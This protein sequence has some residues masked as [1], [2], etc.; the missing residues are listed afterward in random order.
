MII[1]LWRLTQPKANSIKGGK[2]M[3]PA[4]MSTDQI[5][6]KIRNHYGEVNKRN[7]AVLDENYTPDIV[8]HALQFGIE[9][10][11]LE[12]M[13]PAFDGLFTAFPDFHLAVED[14]IV[15]G[16]KAAFRITM[17]GTQKGKFMN[18][19]PTGQK[20]T[21]TSFVFLRLEGNKIAEQWEK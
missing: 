15:E 1:G 19:A 3:S 4:K 6:A 10:K 7:L 18:Q 14:I 21:Q 12:A 13:K 5:K 8:V 9:I 11:G 17:T 20:M 16:D 2:Y